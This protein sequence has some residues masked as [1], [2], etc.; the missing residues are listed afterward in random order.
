MAAEDIV[1]GQSVQLL[2]EGDLGTQGSGLIAATLRVDKVALV[3]AG[4]LSAGV[5]QARPVVQGQMELLSGLQPASERIRW[6][7]RRD[8]RHRPLGAG[9][10]DVQE[11]ATRSGRPHCAAA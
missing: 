2:F 6:L 9:S 8:A 1:S 7:R 4:K 3:A 5:E 10:M 11:R